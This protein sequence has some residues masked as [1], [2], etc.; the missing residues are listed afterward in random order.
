MGV[1]QWCTTEID[2]YITS[3]SLYIRACGC[4]H[5]SLCSIV[6]ESG[7]SVYSASEEAQKELP[8]YDVSLRGAGML[9]I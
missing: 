5:V 4:V 8:G 1:F 6:S 3:S 7:A 2:V 9:H